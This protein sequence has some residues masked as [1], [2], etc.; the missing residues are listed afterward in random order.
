MN[1]LE[2]LERP[3]MKFTFWKNNRTDEE[4]KLTT[5]EI[6]VKF[7]EYL[8]TKEKSWLEHYAYSPVFL[9][10]FIGAKEDERGLQSVSDENAD[11]LLMDYLRPVKNEYLKSIGL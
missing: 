3:D 2:N 4:F 9:S 1:T 10:F 5:K 8:K 7:V 11:S 6:A